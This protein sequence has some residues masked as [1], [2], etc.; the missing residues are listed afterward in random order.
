MLKKTIRRLG[1]L[2]MVLAMAVSVFAVSASAAETVP[3][4]A[5]TK[6]DFT[7][8]VTTDGN[9]YAPN[10]SFGYTVTNG[11]AGSITDTNNK[12]VP[13]LKGQGGV[14]LTDTVFAPT[15]AGMTD[16]AASYVVTGKIVV[17]A[18]TFTTTGVYHYVV[19]EKSTP[20][21]DGI[22]YDGITYD[23]TQRDL[24]IYVVRENGQLVVK[25]AIMKNG[26][27]KGTGFVNDYGQKNDKIHKVTVTKEVTGLLA[28]KNKEFEFTVSVKGAAGEKYK[29]GYKV[30][31]DAAEQ[32]TY[33]DSTTT[34][35]AE[36]IVKERKIK[37]KDTGCIVIYGLSKTDVYT[38]NEKDYSAEGYTTEKRENSGSITEGDKGDVD[39]TVVN[40]Y[41]TATPGGVIMTIAPYA[42][43]LVVAGAFAV[44]FLSRRNRAE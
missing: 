37:I 32:V 28:D 26:T 27:D 5:E 1:A 34:T 36:G 12:T 31:A 11:D 21:Y 2:A 4:N 38:V 13:V 35:D 6:F 44:V 18:N 24:Y 14:T 40:D 41:D 15:I 30:T 39:I 25:Y 7:K 42:L 29:V 43:M 20:A 8:T 16:V 3:G 19:Q 22:T 23:T 33:V 9:T 17:A 10:T